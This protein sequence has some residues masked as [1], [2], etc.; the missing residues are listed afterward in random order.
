MDFGIRH[1]WAQVTA[2]LWCSCDHD[3]ITQ[4]LRVLV[5]SAVEEKRKKEG[6]RREGRRESKRK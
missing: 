2:Q 6:S 4:P 1:I 5:V 3:Q